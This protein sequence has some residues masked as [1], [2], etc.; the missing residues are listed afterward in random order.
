LHGRA[1]SLDASCNLPDRCE[2]LSHSVIDNLRI[3]EREAKGSPLMPTDNHVALILFMLSHYIADAHMPMHCDARPAEY[4]GFDLHAA[5]EDRWEREVVQYFDVD[6][7]NQRFRYNPQGFPLLRGDPNYDTS[8]L[9][10]VEDELATREFQITYGQ[11]NDN[12]REYLQAV[13]QYS[14][15]L[16]FAWLPEDCD[17]ATIEPDPLQVPHGLGFREMSVAALA[18]AIDAV[19]RVWLRVLRRYLK[20]EKEMIN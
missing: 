4:N 15:L 1:F 11:G 5:V 8:I 2:A 12:V 6:R 16:A 17:P 19:A 18:D 14:Y 20:W 13:C 3:R 10:S 7:F 9:K